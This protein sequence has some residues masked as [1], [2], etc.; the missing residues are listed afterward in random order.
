VDHLQSA[1]QSEAGVPNPGSQQRKTFSTCFDS[2]P[3]GTRFT[4]R[5]A[6]GGRRQDLKAVLRRILQSPPGCPCSEAVS[7]ASFFSNR[8]ASIGLAHEVNAAPSSSSRPSSKR[9]GA[10]S[11]PAAPPLSE[12][13]DQHP[14]PKANSELRFIDSCARA[15]EAPEGGDRRGL[16]R[17]TVDS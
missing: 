8:S 10:I 12:V 9:W 17:T 13:G 7:L 16:R 2:V 6:D 15:R 5:H 1:W 3:G 4:C 14:A 11:S